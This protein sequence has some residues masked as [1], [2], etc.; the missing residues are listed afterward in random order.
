MS[1][2]QLH[3]TCQN[4]KTAPLFHSRLIMFIKDMFKSFSTPCSA[5]IW[6]QSYKT[7]YIGVWV[8]HLVSFQM[9]YLL[10]MSSFIDSQCHNLHRFHFERLLSLMFFSA[11]SRLI[12][13]AHLVGW[14]HFCLVSSCTF[15]SNTEGSP[16]YTAFLEVDTV[17]GYCDPSI[18]F[19]LLYQMYGPWEKPN[20]QHI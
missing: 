20:V 11:Q 15:T 16:L 14:K 19:F 17:S 7:A 3:K 10:L 13:K 18:V 9:T 8:L 12:G 4:I 2:E 6:Y 1:E 5:R